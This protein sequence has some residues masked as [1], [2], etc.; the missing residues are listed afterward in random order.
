MRGALEGAAASAEQSALDAEEV[1]VGLH[2]PLRPDD[3]E[4]QQDQREERL[5][6][7]FQYVFEP[8]GVLHRQAYAPGLDELRLRL[9]AIQIIDEFPCIGV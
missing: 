3:H 6:R 2:P 7:L 8:G 1:K 5:P 9:G 4:I